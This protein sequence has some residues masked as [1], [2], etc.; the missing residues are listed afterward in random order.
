MKLLVRAFLL[1]HVCIDEGCFGHSYDVQIGSHH[2]KLLTPSLAWTGERVHVEGWTTPNPFAGLATSPHHV[3]I[4]RDTWGQAFVSNHKA[5]TCAA[6]ISSVML[7]IEIPGD[8]ISTA[9]NGNGQ[10]VSGDAVAEF[11]RQT[12]RWL[13]RV[14]DWV[15]VVADQHAGDPR[16]RQGTDIQNRIWVWPADAGSDCR[17]NVSHAITIRHQ[18][19]EVM[20][21]TEWQCVLDRASHEDEA[22]LERMMLANARNA[23]R[24]GRYREAVLSAATAAEVSLT[25]ELRE[26]A[27][28]DAALRQKIRPRMMLGELITHLQHLNLP[29]E[30]LD[31]LVQPRNQAIHRGQQLT[32]NDAEEAVRLAGSIVQ[33]FSVLSPRL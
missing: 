6:W 8:L 32:L 30:L 9:T 1:S 4:E 18:Q 25:E 31:R 16:L 26:R 24:Q 27:E 13:E 21:K 22:P 17:C 14:R 11:Q 28:L 15:G 10:C 5:R 29:P 19:T 20:N 12:H 2:G 23:L 33:R 3:P 7:E